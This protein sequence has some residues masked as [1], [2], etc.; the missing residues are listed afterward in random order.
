MVVVF[1]VVLSGFAAGLNLEGES[2]LEG[3]F[4]AVEAFGGA[5]AVFVCQGSVAS[6]FEGVHVDCG[7]VVLDCL[8]VVYF[9][10]V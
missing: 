2:V 7:L 10:L 8:E 9:Y 1:V 5:G 6:G 3:V 4:A